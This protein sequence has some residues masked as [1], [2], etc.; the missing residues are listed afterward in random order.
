MYHQTKGIVLHT[1][2]YSETSIIAKIYTS[3]YGLQSYM[4]KG[5]RTSKS[6]N[7]ASL[8]QPLT[9]LDMETS[10][11]QNQQLQ[12]IKECRRDYTYQSIPFDTLK[13]TIALFM[14]EVISKSIREQEENIELFDFIYEALQLLDTS[15]KLHPEFH[16]VF[17]L[18]LSR[19]LGFA[20]HENYSEANSSFEMNE[21]FF[22]T[23][24]ERLH[25]L[26]KNESKLLYDLMQRNFFD[27]TASHLN[28]AERK[29]MLHILLDYYRLHIE[30]F[31]LKSPEILEEVL[32]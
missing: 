9:L 17:L 26:G 4:I 5:V 18:R 22:T 21:G 32:G 27:V 16:L 19:H 24:N 29:K 25:T 15:E 11:R 1:V 2:K 20:P 14:L 6:K 30:N 23:P 28:R 3:Q 8:Y 31:S 12:F 10:H 13:S 7:K